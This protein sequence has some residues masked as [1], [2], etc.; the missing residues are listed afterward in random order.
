MSSK[1]TVTVI[2]CRTY[3][4]R[5]RSFFSTTSS[6][7]TLIEFLSV[8]RLRIPDWKVDCSIL[9]INCYLTST[10]ALMR[11]I[12]GNCLPVINF[13]LF[14]S[15]TIKCRSLRSSDFG[16]IAVHSISF[17]Y[18]HS[19][20][21]QRWSTL[22]YLYSSHRFHR[23]HRQP[24]YSTDFYPFDGREESSITKISKTRTGQNETSTDQRRFVV[25][26]GHETPTDQ[27]RFVV[28]EGHRQSWKWG[29]GTV[30]YTLYST[31]I[32]QWKGW[33]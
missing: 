20:L 16:P 15:M 7:R 10:L 9:H 2:K 30:C 1:V 5:R 11:T 13:P 26:G 12:N 33:C 32:D 14:T 6:R 19:H 22:I 24:R 25:K 17:T 18:S 29:L 21:I 27:R 4:T 31:V 3:S 28:G 23:I 8:D